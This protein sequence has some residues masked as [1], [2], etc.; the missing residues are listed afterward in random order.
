M[1]YIRSSSPTS[2]PSAPPSNFYMNQKLGDSEEQ[3]ESWNVSVQFIPM[4]GL[5]VFLFVAIPMA[6]SKYRDHGMQKLAILKEKRDRDI[7]AR[8]KELESPV[9]AFD[10]K[11][12]IELKEVAA[13]FKLYIV[14]SR[15]FV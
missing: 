13:F 10:V 1:T 6:I 9:Q 11:K 3:S 8:Q 5:S 2:S 12:E 15:E 4:M 7:V 14:F